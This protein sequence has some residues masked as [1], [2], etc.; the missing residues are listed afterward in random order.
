MPRVAEVAVAS[1]PE[2]MR[3]YLRLM[4]MHSPI[5]SWLYLFPGLWSISLASEDVPNLADVALLA[6]GAV[7]VRGAGCT[8]NDIVDRSI[9]A[10]V[11]R[12]VSRPLAA[13]LLSVSRA[14]M[15]AV[16]QTVAALACL[17]VISLPAAIV[18]AGSYP[19]IVAYPFMKRITYWPQAWL[20]LTFNLYGIAGWLV[21]AGRITAPAIFLYIAGFCWTLGYDTIYAHQDKASDVQVGVKS[22]ALLFGAS[23]LQWVA[24]FYAAVILS[25]AAAGAI[26]GL[27]W[28]FF[29]LLL[30]PAGQLLWQVRA[31]DINVPDSCKA[32]FLSNRFFGWLVLASILTGRLVS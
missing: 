19:L 18:V 15:F 16:A 17:A 11:E 26:A 25:I 32:V 27:H 6:I 23:T 7:L 14:V 28:T 3:P 21:A 13:G 22:T 1:S 29:A 12:T 4:R 2:V 5:G 31:V 24:G 30:L 8:I 10:K 9:D 20:A